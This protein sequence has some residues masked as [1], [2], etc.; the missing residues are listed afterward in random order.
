MKQQVLAGFEF[1]SLTN[2]ALCLFFFLFV[3]M[4]IWIFRK[5]S[6]QYYKN[7]SEDILNDE[8]KCE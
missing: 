4:L 1:I 6:S 2:F 8:V 7:V 5:G 3:S